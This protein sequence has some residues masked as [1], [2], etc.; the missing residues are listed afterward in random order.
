[1]DCLISV[2]SL[3]EFDSVIRSEVEIVDL[4]DP[5]LGPLAP[6]TPAIWVAVAEQY[7]KWTEGNPMPSPSRSPLLSAA[8]G[9]GLQALQVAALLPR[10]FRFAK[11]GPSECASPNKL[12][13]LWSEV[14]ARLHEQIE[15]VAVA[16]AD[17]QLANSLHPQQVFQLAAKHGFKRCLVDT[18]TKDGRTSLDFL[19]TESLAELRQLTSDQK[20][21]FAIAGSI[22]KSE[23]KRLD[24]KGVR[25]D[26]YAVRGVVC[27]HDRS[28]GIS[29]ARLE[30]WLSF[31]RSR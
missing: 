24:S 19:T 5:N 14:R 10:V 21:W 17:W 1:V 8:L 12:V 20:M 2:Q 27:Q 4:K 3:S 6:T 11:A 13:H 23:V 22:T 7:S 31:I 9:E 25:P 18:Y 16:Y 15:L 26:C 30:D 28:S 29:P